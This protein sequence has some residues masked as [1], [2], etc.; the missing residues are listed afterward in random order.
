[1]PRMLPPRP[2]ADTPESERKVFTAFERHL[3]QRLDRLPLP[4]HRPSTQGSRSRCRAGARLPRHRPGTG[5]PRVRGEGRGRDRPRRGGLVFRQQPPSSDQGAGSA[6]AVCDARVAGLPADARRSAGVR[7]GRGLPGCRVA[8]Y[9]RS[10]IAPAA[11]DRP[12]RPAVGRQGRGRSVRSGGRRRH[13][14]VAG[15]CHTTRA[16]ARAT[17]VAGAIARRN[18]HGRRR[19]ARAAHR[20][21]VQHSRTALRLSAGRC[22]GWRGHR[23]DAGGDGARAPP[24][25]RGPARPAALLQ[26]RARRLSETARRRV[27]RVDV[28]FA[29]RHVV[30]IR[31]APVAHRPHRPG[32]AGVLARRGAGT[33]SPGTG[34]PAGRTFRCRHRRRRAGLP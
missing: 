4:A 5:A 8:R 17:R 2:D 25:R 11:G 6:G 23:K 9:A 31:R 19:C 26:P 1:M 27:R 33:S 14:P 34:S 16:A 32:R 10:G 21:A 3:P 30:Q 7:M 15:G 12:R 18:R 28:P 29:V 13:S 20:G 22:L 24:R